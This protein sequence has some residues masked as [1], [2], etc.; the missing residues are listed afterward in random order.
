MDDIGLQ[1]TNFP[2]YIF[3]KTH[4]YPKLIRK[5]Q[6]CY[7]P[8]QRVVIALAGD[9][10]FTI[11]AKSMI[12]MIQ[13]LIIEGASP[14]SHEIL[15][16]MYKVLDFSKRAKTLELFMTEWTPLPSKNPPYSSSSFPDRTRHKVIVL[17]YFLG[18]YLDQWLDEAITGFLSILSLESKPSI[19]FNF[20]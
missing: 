12:Q 18:Y 16:E 5:F 10:L 6:S 2:F 8:Q 9:I 7:N 17:S 15:S 19:L 4:S 3:P 11:D 1:D 13:A 20:C 14:F